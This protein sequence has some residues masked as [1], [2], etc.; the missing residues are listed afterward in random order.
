[1]RT[2][3][4]LP[5]AALA[6]ALMLTAGAVNASAHRLALSNQLFRIVW[7]SGAEALRIETPAAELSARCPV[8]IEGSFHSRTIS[9]VSGQLIGYVTRAALSVPGCEFTGGAEAMTILTSSLPEH[10][11]YDTFTGTLPSIREIGVEVA[12]FSV[13]IRAFGVSCL[14]VSTQEE[15]WYLWAARQAASI[16]IDVLIDRIKSRLLKHE[17]GALCPSSMT[18]SGTGSPTVLSSTAAIEVTLVS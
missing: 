8:T 5:L 17:G 7:P 4:R 1:M 2:Y 16:L 18:S 6:A 13:L 15:P 9:K 12:G 14:Y 3:V 11:H 10:I